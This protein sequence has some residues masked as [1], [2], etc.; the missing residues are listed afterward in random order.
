[1]NPWRKA[2]E[3]LAADR[4]EQHA[5]FTKERMQRINGPRAGGP[6]PEL[7]APKGA[8]PWQP[9]VFKSTRGGPLPEMQRY[10]QE[11]MP[12]IDYQEGD[13]SNYMINFLGTPVDMRKINVPRVK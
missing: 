12:E 2:Q 10:L 3:L 1:M 9:P 11:Q 5:R 8:S 13:P 6:R 4:V 7:R